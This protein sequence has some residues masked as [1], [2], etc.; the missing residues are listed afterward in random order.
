M[1]WVGGV[2]VKR[3]DGDSGAWGESEDDGGY[4]RYLS[5]RLLTSLLL[6]SSTSTVGSSSVCLSVFQLASVRTDTKPSPSSTRSMRSG[7]EPRNE[8]LVELSGEI[9]SPDLLAL[10][11]LSVSPIISPSSISE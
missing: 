7:F 1:K 6:K 3:L 10:P 4:E 9:S 5:F 11:F 8:T 2:T